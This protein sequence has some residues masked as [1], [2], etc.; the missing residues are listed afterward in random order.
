LRVLFINPHQ[1]HLVSR[2][3]KIFNRAWPPLELANCGA[4]L[5]KEGHEVQILDANA[6]GLLA[7]QV[8]PAA[9][10][11]DRVFISSS[12]LD[13][14][15]C[16]NVDL[17]PFLQAVSNV[18]K[19]ND[20]IYILGA[21]GTVKPREVLALTRARAVVRGEPELTVA[22][23]CR[24][25]R[26]GDIQGLAFLENG[27][28]TMTPDRAPLDL[29]ALQTPAFHLLPM[30]RYFYE[31]LGSRFTLFEGSRGC[32]FH[33]GFCLL[34][35]YGR[36]IRRKSLPRLIEEVEYA[37][38]RFGVKT[39]YFMDLEFTIFREQVID[40][41]DY[42][43]EKKHDFRWTCQTR[44]DL[45]DEMLL[46][47]MK[48]AGCR[49]IHFGV[50]AGSD[51]RLKAVN[52]RITVRQIENGMRLVH[53]AK[54]ESACFFILGFPGSTLREIEET[55][56]FA[57]R[58]NPTYA[59]FHI[60]V[61]YPETLLYNEMRLNGTEDVGDDLFPEA[62]VTGEELKEL[63]TLARKA[64]G[65]FYLRPR[66]IFSRLAKGDIPSLARQIKLFFGYL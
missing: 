47:K 62:C 9:A 39:A 56:S 6:L 8:A 19:F 35:M 5:E 57:R 28:L 52:K 33:C 53:K 2:R 48:R 11:F 25:M 46:D 61:P 15:Q 41:C 42:L 14:W 44:F 40:L 65:G 63:K 34:K 20:E 17:G 36:G 12:S 54:I 3:G 37:I 59:L 30:D 27:Q 18:K 50:E 43:I 24:N 22:D 49:L 38:S 26:P 23:I 7:G 55:I 10:G 32:S 45:V 31:V 1:I 58:L 51:E 29:D 64:Y 4:L 66:Y 13:R 16:P 60:A 21:H